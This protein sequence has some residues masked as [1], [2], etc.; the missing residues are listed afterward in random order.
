MISPFHCKKNP[1]NPFFFLSE[2][3]KW[4]FRGASRLRVGSWNIGTLTGKSIKL[5]KILKK[6]KI[7]MACIQDTKWVGPKAKEVDGYK[8]WFSGRSKCR[9]VV[10]ILVDGELRDQV[11]EVRRATDRMMS[12]KVVVEG[13]TVNII[14]AYASQAGLGDEEKRRFWED[15]DE[16]VG[17]IP[18]TEKLFVGGDFNGH[19]GLISGGYDDVHGGFGFGDRNGGGV[20]LLDFARASGLVIA[21]SSFPKK[22]EH[23]VT[24]RSSV[25][26]TQIDFLQID[27]LLLKKDDKGLCKDCKVIPSEYLTTRHKLLVM[28]LAIKMT[29]KERVV[30]DRHRIRWGSL[31]T[32]SALEMGEKLKDMGAWDSS[33][34]ATSMWDKTTSCIRVVAREVLGVSTGSRG[35]H[36]GDWWWNGEVQGKVKAKKV[37]YAKLIES[38]DEV[39]KWTNTKLYKMARKEAKLA[40]STAKTTAFERMYAELEEKGGDQK[41]F[42][43]AKARERKARDVDQVKCI[44]DEHDKVL[45]EETLI[46]RRWQSYF[47][48]LLNEE[49][50]RDIVLGELEHTGRRHDFGYCRS[51][52]VDEVK[53]AVRRMRRGRATGPDEIP[54]KFWKSVGPACLEWLTRLFNV[55][56]KTALMPEEWRA[57]VMIPLYKNKGDIQSCNNYR[58]IKLLSHTMKVWERVVEM[59]VRR[60]VSI[61]ENQFG[62]MP[63]R[64]TTEAIHLV[65]R[66][67]E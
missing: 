26:K 55:I 8:L 57:S 25:A 59:R 64:S 6:R 30:E 2:S 51:I 1:N 65:R 16:L 49:G 56:F 27:F 23:L 43:L 45:V 50:D 47:C 12:I 20:S 19:I 33:G 7:N 61:S 58:G 40:V 62:F 9:N 41:L 24:F 44:K 28:D 18:P 54:E 13:L 5:V 31:T 21:N 17:G 10:G 67:V 11:V 60:G 22:E 14:S 48:K 46:R 37:A 63:E 38:K 4:W 36:R 15:L 39:E 32:I 52:K 42:R 66:L 34:D 29:R 35:Q 53:G 3:G